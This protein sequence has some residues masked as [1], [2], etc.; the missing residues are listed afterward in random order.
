[1]SSLSIRNMN[2][3]DRYQKELEGRAAPMTAADRHNSLLDAIQGA[4]NMAKWAKGKNDMKKFWSY[5]HVAYRLDAQLV[6]LLNDQ[7]E[8]TRGLI[9]GF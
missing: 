5:I 4:V 7:A 8:D 6:A 3:S 2:H 1:M 9:F